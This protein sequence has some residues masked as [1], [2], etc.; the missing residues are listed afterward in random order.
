MTKANIKHLQQQFGDALTKIQLT[1]M[2]KH[3]IGTSDI[4]RLLRQ[5][6]NIG[7]ESEEEQAARIK[8]MQE[9]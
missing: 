2:T 6:P 3:G 9:I 4:E 1:K 7:K 8:K 5:N